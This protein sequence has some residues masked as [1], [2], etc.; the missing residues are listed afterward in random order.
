MRDKWNFRARFV[1][2]LLGKNMRNARKGH[3]FDLRKLTKNCIIYQ[4]L[5]EINCDKGELTFR[6][7][8]SLL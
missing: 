4:S 8:R 1:N 3:I 6:L 2:E 5:F 7:F